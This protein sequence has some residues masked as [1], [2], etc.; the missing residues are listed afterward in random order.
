[1]L[2]RVDGENRI[3]TL[4]EQLEFQKNLHSEVR[5]QRLILWS[6][7]SRSGPGPSCML[8][9][10]LCS[11]T[12]GTNDGLK[13]RPSVGPGVSEQVETLQEVSPRVLSASTGAARDQTAPRV[14]GGGAGQ[15]PPAGL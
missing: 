6:V 12:P 13:L 9:V 1:M 14:P 2:R 3:Q 10:F 15:R 11:S 5:D 8:Y 4:K 7:R